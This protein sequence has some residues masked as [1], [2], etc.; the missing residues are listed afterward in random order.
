MRDIRTPC[1]EWVKGN[2]LPPDWKCGS[3]GGGGGLKQ[4]VYSGH[5]HAQAAVLVQ[6]PQK[7]KTSPETVTGH[8]EE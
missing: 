4:K 1:T 7:L 5:N 8:Q 3:G 6:Q 2:P